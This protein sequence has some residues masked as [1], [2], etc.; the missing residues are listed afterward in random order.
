MSSAASSASG[1]RVLIAATRGTFL[2]SHRLPLARAARAAG[3]EVH[4]AARADAARAQLEAEGFPFHPLPCEPGGLNPI[5]EWRFCQ[6]LRGLFGRLRPDLVHLVALKTVAWGGLAAD[7]AGPAV[8]GMLTGLGWAFV[9]PGW[10][11]RLARL[12]IGRLLRAGSRRLRRLYTVQNADDQALLL[13]EGLVPAQKLRRLKGSGVAP[14][15]FPPVPEPETEVP[16]VVM[17]ARLLVDKG[18]GEFAAAGRRLRRRGIRARFALAGGE[19]PLNRAALP[20]ETVQ[21][22]QAAGDLEWWGER[23]DMAGVLAQANL[24]CLPSYR[25]GLPRALVEAAAVGRALVATDVPGCREIVRPGENGLLVPPCDA[26]A[27]ATALA[28]LLAD[29]A[30]RREMGRRSRE[31]FFQGFDLDSVNAATLALY[32]ELLTQGAVEK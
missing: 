11:A 25:E 30:R 14:A 21:A 22:W 17:P 8:L 24:V 9:A 31:I 13:A 3:Y 1:H 23:T 16:L 29:P 19:D 6:S 18:V 7:P 10:R 27:L 15:E 32:E 12:V 5:Q 28:E 2:A 26:E 20:R 4:F